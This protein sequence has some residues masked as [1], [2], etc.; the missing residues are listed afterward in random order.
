MRKLTIHKELFKTGQTGFVKSCTI[1]NTI[2]FHQLDWDLESSG[3]VIIMLLTFAKHLFNPSTHVR[4][5][6][7]VLD[8]GFWILDPT[9]WI[10]VQVLDSGCFVSGTGIP[11]SNR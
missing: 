11:D 4:E 1:V 5:S 10:L 9:P 8:S 7:T 6:K 2:Q 3:E